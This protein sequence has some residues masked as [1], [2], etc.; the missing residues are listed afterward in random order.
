MDNQRVAIEQVETWA[1]ELDALMHRIGRR[2][3]RSE[4]RQRARAYLQGLL[5][6]AQR[7]NGWQLAEIMGDTTPYGVQQFLYRAVWNPDDLRDDLRAYVVDALGDPEAVLIVDETGFLKKGRHSAG[8][9][10][11]YSGTAGRIENSQVGVFLA[12]ASAHGHAFLDRALYL[13]EEWASDPARRQAA[14]I[15]EAVTFASKPDLAWDMLRQ[16]V[17]QQVPFRWVTADSIYGDYRSLRLWLES[18]PKPYVLAVS[19]KETVVSAWQQQRVGAL[20]DALPQDGWQRLSAGAGAK[21]PRLYDWY[22]LPLMDP[23]VAGWKRWL[24]VRRSISDPNELAGYVCFAPAGTPLSELVRVAGRRWMIEASLE[25]A[26]DEVGL[27]QYEV[28][29]W[30]GWYRHITLALLAHALLAVVQAQAGAGDSSAAKK[31]ALLPAQ[32]SHSLVAFKT[33]RGLSCH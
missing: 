29:R 25:E 19:R 21:G 18:L 15:P 1:A 33:S 6:P 7:K 17:A 8:V 10:R 11:Q 12:Y 26:K 22:W 13:P 5:S 9:K 32:T 4:A 23:L 16:A 14:G 3:V 2:F 30:S 24:L 31:G 20:L 28:R 27:D